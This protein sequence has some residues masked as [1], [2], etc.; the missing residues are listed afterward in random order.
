MGYGCED[1]KCVAGKINEKFRVHQIWCEAA[2][3]EI[4]EFVVVLYV[5]K[6]KEFLIYFLATPV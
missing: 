1:S 3:C 2:V 4:L 6:R 5:E